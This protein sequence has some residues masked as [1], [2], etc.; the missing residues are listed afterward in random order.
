MIY[1]YAMLRSF[2]FVGIGGAAGSMARFGLG[3]IISRNITAAF[4]FGTFT[5][6]IL[7]SFIIGMLAGLGMKYQWLQGQHTGWL[8]LATGFCG[9]FTTFSSFAYENISLIQRG[10][11]LTPML[12]TALSIVTGFILCFAGMRLFK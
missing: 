3:Y 6:N 11:Y 4:P 5:I 7:G 1:L 9:G 2:L 12:Y 10:Q 8:L